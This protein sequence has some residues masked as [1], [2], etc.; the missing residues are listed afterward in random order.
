MEDDSIALEED[1]IYFP[2]VCCDRHLRRKTND[3]TAFG[4]VSVACS[5]FQRLKVNNN[6][7]EAPSTSM[8]RVPA[9]SA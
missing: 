8:D 9:V 1:H 3:A 2:M 7:E 5:L 6:R 4:L